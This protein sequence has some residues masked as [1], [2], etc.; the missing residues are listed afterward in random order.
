MERCIY[1]TGF[2]QRSP[3]TAFHAVLF[4]LR[5]L[6]P[7]RMQSVSRAIVLQT[8][9][10]LLYLR[11]GT[12]WNADIHSGHGE[13]VHRQLIQRRRKRKKEQQSSVKVSFYCHRNYCAYS[14]ETCNYS[15]SL[16]H[17]AHVQKKNTA[18]NKE[19]VYSAT[20]N[21]ISS[22]YTMGLKILASWSGLDQQHGQNLGT[23]NCKVYRVQVNI[24]REQLHCL[25]RT[26]QATRSQEAV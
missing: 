22:K 3:L 9:S 18:E 15:K 5:M 6:L 24:I 25:F 21:F 26:T 16:K 8:A 7:F 20:S 13:E 1:G 10:W 23:E 4:L 17:I 2:G 19:A 14:N 12:C 11:L